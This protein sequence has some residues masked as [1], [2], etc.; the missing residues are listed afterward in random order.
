M[1][2]KL[3]TSHLGVLIDADFFLGNHKCMHLN[4]LGLTP[5]AQVYSS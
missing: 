2:L 1:R 3:K 5:K 4:A